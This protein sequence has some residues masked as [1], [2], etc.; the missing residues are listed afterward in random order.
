M[1]EKLSII[2]NAS[3]IKFEENK[4]I[5]FDR[6]KENLSS[7]RVLKDGYM[8]IHLQQGIIPDEEGY[9]LAKENLSLKRPYKF[10]LETGK[11]KRDKTEKILS[12][13]ELFE[14]AETALGHISS[15]YPD[16]T[17]KGCFEQFRSEYIMEN[18]KGLSYT[19]IDCTVNASFTFKHKDSN[20]IVDGSFSLGMRDYD[21]EKLYILADNFLGTY[22]NLV[23]LP[24]EFA[25]QMPYYSLLGKLYEFLNAER[26]SLGTS[27]LAGRIG[28]KIFNE[29][30]TICHDVSDEETWHT[31]FFDGEGITLENDK[32]PYIE[33]G[34][35]L[36]GYADK[37]TADKYGVEHTGSASIDFSDIPCN[38]N[39]NL[40]IK[41]SDKTIKELLDGKLSIVP[42]SYSG[43]GFNDKG[44]YNMPIHLAYLCDGEKFIGRLGSFS[45]TN[46]SFLGSFCEDFIGV[47]SDNPIFNDK[48]IVCKCG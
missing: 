37:R 40:R 16:F 12:D 20:N 34:V 25:L 41:R 5:S 23:E 6:K 36:R 32:L 33:N 7:Y 29:N 3:E 8:G 13:K 39:V 11:R 21:L 28:E 14:L 27:L 18:N 35:L 47:G 22:D 30:F 26:M 17:L 24:E 4:I 38:G 2:L 48:Q 9:K 10:D 43:G 42:V 45:L 15:K 19:N 1:R 46:N 31:P 44:E